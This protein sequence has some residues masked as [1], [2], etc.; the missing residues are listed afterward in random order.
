MA[1][2]IN[3]FSFFT[4]FL[5]FHSARAARVR[6][7]KRRKGVRRGY[8]RGYPKGEAG[9]RSGDAAES[10]QG[11]PENGHDEAETH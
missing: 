11:Y 8:S 5:F 6:Y 10:S 1:V 4:L 7:E 2:T 3:F 9:A